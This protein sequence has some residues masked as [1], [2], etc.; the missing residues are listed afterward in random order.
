[1][2][3]EQSP[4]V[5]TETSAPPAPDITQQV[6]KPAKN[7]KRVAAGKAVAEKTRQACQ[8][9]KKALAEANVIIA[10]H[11]GKKAGERQ[12]PVEEPSPAPE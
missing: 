6:T 5:A 7:P 1:M 4:Q 12:P 2:S 11:K 10:N 3:A 8:V 9:Q